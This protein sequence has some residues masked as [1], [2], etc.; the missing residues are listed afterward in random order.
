MYFSGVL[1][2]SLIS[3]IAM[4]L[5]TNIIAPADDS[6]V[7]ND[8]PGTVTIPLRVGPR[9]SAP[10]IVRDDVPGTAFVPLRVGPRPSA[11]S[12]DIHSLGSDGVGFTKREANSDIGPGG[13]VVA[14][15]AEVAT[16]LIT[17]GGANA[18]QDAIMDN[19]CKKEVDS[20][21]KKK[22]KG[23]LGKIWG[24]V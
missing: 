5:P 6:E 23:K 15:A 1:I 21:L 3:S 22:I 2:A 17:G 4:A 8:V 24:R 7:Y 16:Q 10:S 12:I 14:T 20:S 18:N 13:F 19:Y 9:V 11:P